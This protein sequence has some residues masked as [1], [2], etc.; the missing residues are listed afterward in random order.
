M[1]LV[2]K[3]MLKLGKVS[4]QLFKNHKLFV[5]DLFVYYKKNYILVSF[6]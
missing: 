6:Y 1:Q 2:S 4:N 3:N 5:V